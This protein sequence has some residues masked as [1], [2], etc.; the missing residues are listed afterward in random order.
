MFL[1]L[2][3]TSN[4]VKS[5][6]N[7]LFRA[8]R[9]RG[10]GGGTDLPDV[11]RSRIY[12]PIVPS[13]SAFREASVESRSRVSA[14]IFQRYRGYYANA[15]SRALESLGERFNGH[16]GF[17]KPDVN[18]THIGHR[19]S[20]GS[21]A[22]R[23]VGI[24]DGT[25]LTLTR[26]RRTP[27]RRV[28]GFFVVSR[29]PRKRSISPVSCFFIRAIFKTTRGHGRIRYQ[30]KRIRICARE[31]K[32]FPLPPHRPMLRF[33]FDRSFFSLLSFVTRESRSFYSD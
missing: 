33:I 1:Y 27:T 22:F 31:R 13:L 19:R 28:P 30:G 2:P 20:R 4:L 9:K 12:R 25:T 23:Y 15:T 11:S 29:P 7:I 24:G 8:D 16:S 3:T 21:I 26:Q 5:S 6:R 14:A 17:A 10:G 18:L 32:S